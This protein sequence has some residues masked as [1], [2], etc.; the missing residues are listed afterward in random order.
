MCLKTA[1]RKKKKNKCL[2][3]YFDTLANE[4]NYISEKLQCSGNKSAMPFTL[5]SYYDVPIVTAIFK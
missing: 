3:I 1:L 2:K 5:N 4:S